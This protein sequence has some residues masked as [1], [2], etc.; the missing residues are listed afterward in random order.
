MKSNGEPSGSRAIHVTGAQAPQSAPTAR[1][2][3]AKPRQE[4]VYPLGV[5]PPE[6]ALAQVL[7]R[8]PAQGRDRCSQRRARSA[9]RRPGR[10]FRVP[11][12]PRR[13]SNTSPL[14]KAF[15]HRDALA[16]PP[17]RGHWRAGTARPASSRH[18][19]PVTA[20]ARPPRRTRNSSAPPVGALAAVERGPATQLH[21]GADLRGGSRQLEVPPRSGLSRSAQGG[22]TEHPR[23][24]G[25]LE[26]DHRPWSRQAESIP[27]TLGASPACG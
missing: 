18:P 25:A 21:G 16:H 12:R 17:A 23:A 19:R 4:G 11:R 5:R 24:L 7:A 9:P 15:N 3:L 10:L 13:S 27:V 20:R 26:R 14:L 8:D 1:N 2:P 22:K 6:P